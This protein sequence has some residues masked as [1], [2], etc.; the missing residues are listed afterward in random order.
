MTRGRFA[1]PSSFSASRQAARQ[2]G[3]PRRRAPRR[4]RGGAPRRSG[5]TSRPRTSNFSCASGTGNLAVDDARAGDAEHPAQ[6]LLRPDRAVLAGGRAGDGDRLSL[7]ADFRGAGA[8][9]PVDRVLQD[10]GDRAVV[11]RRDDQER[12]G[13]FDPLAQLA[14]R[15]RCSMP[16]RRGPGRRRDAPALVELDVDAGGASS[17]AARARAVLYD[18]A[19]RLPEMARIFMSGRLT[20]AKFALRTTSFGSRKSPPGSGRVPV[21]PE[22]R[23]V[24]GSRELDADPVVPL[25]RRRRRRSCP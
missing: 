17:T 10:A 13:G 15:G 16:R 7:S 1:R 20:A 23:S 8:R 19:R 2:R 21:E 25:G 5:S 9:R 3:A 4:G 24:D 6:V 22:V 14:H 11:L 18:S 12:V